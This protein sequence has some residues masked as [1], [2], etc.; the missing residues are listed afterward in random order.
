MDGWQMNFIFRGEQL[1]LGR[2]G[3]SSCSKPPSYSTWSKFSETSPVCALDSHTR[4]G[5][6]PLGVEY[7]TAIEQGAQWDA[8]VVIVSMWH[9]IWESMDGVVCLFL[10]CVSLFVCLF[11]YV[12]LFIFLCIF[13]WFVVWLLVSLFLF[14]FC[15]SWA[16]GM[17]FVQT[18][19]VAPKMQ[20]HHMGKF[21]GNQFPLVGNSPKRWWKVREFSPKCC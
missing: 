17:C 21:H 19:M 7:Q 14:L 18:S 4:T 15:T 20:C 11:V 6:T 12:F 3:L 9:W 16:F 10:F 8:D 1:V 2:V 5:Q 13:G